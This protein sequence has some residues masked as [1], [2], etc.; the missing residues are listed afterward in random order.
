MNVQ[1]SECS[2]VLHGRT[3][4]SILRA[5]G[6]RQKGK[7][8]IVAGTHAKPFTTLLSALLQ[9]AIVAAAA[10]CAQAAVADVDWGSYIGGE[11]GASQVT[12]IT[13]D[14]AGNVLA[15]GSAAYDMPATTGLPSDGVGF[16]L[17][18]STNDQLVWS[19]HL[20]FVPM[21]VAV[22]GLGCIWLLGEGSNVLV[23]RIPASGPATVETIYS[24]AHTDTLGGIVA[25]AD[26]NAY[27]TGETSD[28]DFPVTPGLG[29]APNW[30][31]VWETYY[32]RFL[33]K[34]GPDGSLVWSQWIGNG[35]GDTWQNIAIDNLGNVFVCGESIVGVNAGYSFWYGGYAQVNAFVA[36]FT[37]SGDAPWVSY[38]PNWEAQGLTCDSTGNIYV[39]G[40][41]C[42]PD[43]DVPL[44]VP[45]FVAKL[46][47]WGEVAWLVPIYEGRNPKEAYSITID[48]SGYC[49]TGPNHGNIVGLDAQ[50]SILWVGNL[51][52]NTVYHASAI[53]ADMRGNL[54][55]GGYTEDSDFPAIDGFNTD[56]TAAGRDGYAVRVR[57]FGPRILTRT[58]PN[59]FVKVPYHAQF[60]AADG[61]PPYSWRVISQA[62]P[63]GLELSTSGE[64][65]GTPRSIGVYPFTVE[66]EDA[67]GHTKHRSFSISIDTV[68]PVIVTT[69]LKK[70]YVNKSYAD[71]L[72]ASGDYGP[73]TWSIASGTLP[74]GLSLDPNTGAIGGSPYT[75][76]TF[77]FVAQVRDSLGKTDQKVFSIAVEYEDAGGPLVSGVAAVP[78]TI[79]ETID[80]SVLVTALADG[81]GGGNHA[82]TDIQYSVSVGGVSGPWINMS[83]DDGSFDSVREHAQVTIDTSLWRVADGPRTISVRA[84]DSLGRP[85][86]NAASVVIAVIDSIAPGRVFTLSLQPTTDLETVL[87]GS[88]QTP[89]KPSAMDETK[90]FDLGGL[91]DIG[92]VALTPATTALFPRRFTIE[93]S[94]DDSDWRT[95]SSH[96]DYRAVKGANVWQFDPDEYRYVRLTATAVYNPAAGCYQT[97][98]PR[99]SILGRVDG[100]KLRAKWMASADDGYDSSSGWTDKSD[101]RFSASAITESNFLSCR[102]VEAVGAP[103]APGKFDETVF[104]A[105]DLQGAIFGAVKV[106][107]A[108]GNPSPLSNVEQAQV[109]YM[110]L[111]YQDESDLIV[112]NPSLPPQLVIS[113]GKDVTQAFIAFSG[114]ISFSKN[115][116]KFPIKAGRYAWSPT[117]SQ[118]K[119]IK[120]TASTLGV[121]YWRLE[122]KSPSCPSIILA[123]KELMLRNGDITNLAASPI[124]GDRLMWPDAT[125]FPAFSWTNGIPGMAYFWVDISTD[126]AFATKSAKKLIS[127]TGASGSATATKAQ[128]K[129]IRRLAAASGGTLYWRVRAKDKD[130]A[131]TLA[132]QTQT[133]TI[134]GG[135]WT[136]SDVTST[137]DGPMIS[138]THEGQGIATYR[139][140]FTA[141]ETFSAKPGST[142]FVPAS[143]ISASS[144]TLK[145]TEVARLRAF[146]RHAKATTLHYRVRGED[147]EK[148]FVTHSGTAAMT[149]P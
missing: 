103:V 8:M 12:D 40:E 100:G 126:S 47:T 63:D 106:F 18:I 124:H 144:Y 98:I 74:S 93:V 81:W 41:S 10:G 123:P 5:A 84:H 59:G 64:I 22:D 121:V 134:D 65:P 145:S 76:R 131:L 89:G 135:V 29:T 7:Q 49:W 25:D 6:R 24:G 149:L 56:L 72:T 70:G 116:L 125:K 66:L 43:N 37:P 4:K 108:S 94:V 36:K 2:G 87:T 35:D 107:D 75:A 57:M 31:E 80:R 137:P 128:W 9:A 127:L 129:A 1:I 90:S 34:F 58:L 114:S 27:V 33:V 105:G 96:T 30:G 109:T 73:F 15:V 91:K 20:D 138:W 16:I 139:L 147:A 130:K 115:H 97:T 52:S 28:H 39:T 55:L 110:G 50:G 11:I 140:E 86:V 117:A 42:T 118:W 83:P 60:E 148:A 141:S 3:P 119:A 113:R 19:R 69:S 111:S 85:S 79:R 54:W 77:S 142:V 46:H 17:K 78:N 101:L 21:S 61:H 13:V 14:P 88:W 62:V 82:V 38:L 48:G 146:A 67:C 71:A 122:G 112:I 32:G 136:V 95:I 92:G 132:S 102:K 45:T 68:P 51:G 44:A 53:R 99:V 104:S 143:S 26:G 120:K 133:L 23:K